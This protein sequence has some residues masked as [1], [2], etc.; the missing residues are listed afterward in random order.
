MPGTKAGVLNN[1]WLQFLASGAGGVY[2]RKAEKAAVGAAP[3]PVPEAVPPQK[4]R[5]KKRRRARAKA[6][7]PQDSPAA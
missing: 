3:E 7:P 5:G 4:L 6:R 2:Q 1:P